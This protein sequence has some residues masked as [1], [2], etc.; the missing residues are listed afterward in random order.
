MLLHLDGHGCRHH[1]H[2]RQSTVTPVYWRR[3][4]TEAFRAGEGF[5]S[6]IRLENIKSCRL[7]NVW[8]ATRIRSND[9]GVPGTPRMRRVHLLAEGDRCDTSRRHAP[10]CATQ[11]PACGM[12]T[13][14]RSKAK[15]KAEPFGSGSGFAV[16]SDQRPL[17]PR[18]RRVHSLVEGDRCDTSRRHAPCCATQQPACGMATRRRADKVAAGEKQLLRCLIGAFAKFAAANLKTD[19]TGRSRGF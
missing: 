10:C 18:M 2:S 4:K 14:R 5:V 8:I 9:C 12:A 7:A 1:W 19:E 15:A 6:R 11:Q 17:T 16:R 13:R 3:V